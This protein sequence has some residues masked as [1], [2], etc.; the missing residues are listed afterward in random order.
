LKH[1][2]TILSEP[3][4]L[5]VFWRSFKLAATCTLLCLLIAYP[6]AYFFTKV[7]ARYK[8]LL[9]LL[10]IIPFWTSSLIRTYAIISMLKAKGILNTGLMALGLIQTPIQLL[11]TPIAVIIGLVYDLLPF[12]I[13]PLYTSF[14]K[15]NPLYV[16]AARDLG[17]NRFMVFS[18]IIFPLTLPGIF[19]GSLLVFLP[20]MSIFY[21]PDILGGSKSLLLGNLI[22][23][24][25]LMNNWPLG[26]ALSVI[27]ISMLIIFLAIGHRLQKGRDFYQDFV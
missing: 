4:Y 25:F 20:A 8:S 7:K 10:I 13:L 14:E 12:M 17:A 11:H 16:D 5:K 18:K 21:I 23:R 3:L 24:Q 2:F 27:L 19:S 9:L 26:A 6:F 15:L 22:Q 1:Y